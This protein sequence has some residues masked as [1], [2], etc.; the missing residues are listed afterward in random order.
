MNRAGS[1]C[2]NDCGFRLDECHRRHRHRLS[3]R[4][5]I[6]LVVNY[7]TTRVNKFTKDDEEKLIRCSKYLNQANISS[8]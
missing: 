6:L 8:I 1:E 7:L 2:C 3:V 5:D 4:P